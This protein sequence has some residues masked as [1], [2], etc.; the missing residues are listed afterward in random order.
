MRWLLRRDWCNDRSSSCWFLVAFFY[1]GFFSHFPFIMSHA[2]VA[3][4][5]VIFG[6]HSQI[7]ALLGCVMD[8]LGFPWRSS[9][10]LHS[11][12]RLALTRCSMRT[13]GICACSV[14]TLRSHRCYWSISGSR[15]ISGSTWHS[16]RNLILPHPC[17]VGTR[18][19]TPLVPAA[20]SLCPW[21]WCSSRFEGTL[22]LEHLPIFLVGFFLVF[23]PG[24][25][26]YLFSRSPWS[27]I[28]RLGCPYHRTLLLT[29]RLL[30]W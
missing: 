30:F 20:Y 12:V 11:L 18:T 24:P 1:R 17:P 7:S 13:C 28:R 19:C 27:R 5:R 29:T 22:K 4:S 21:R 16:R 23:S 25:L 15:Q 6:L 8:Y 14:A 2:T 3:V 10:R 9:P 26:T